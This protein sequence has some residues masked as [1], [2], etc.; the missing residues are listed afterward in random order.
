MNHG[1]GS[2]RLAS[3]SCSKTT[4]QLFRE[5]ITALD[6]LSEHLKAVGEH[7]RMYKVNRAWHQLW[8]AR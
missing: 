1:K 4:E 6:I 8:E 3:A 5:A 2:N 7:D